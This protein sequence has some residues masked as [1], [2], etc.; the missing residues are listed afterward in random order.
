MM[1]ASDMCDCWRVLSVC[2]VDVT[3]VNQLNVEFLPSAS[4]SVLEVV[5]AATSVSFFQ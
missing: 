1:I 3:L 2:F 4:D 5:R